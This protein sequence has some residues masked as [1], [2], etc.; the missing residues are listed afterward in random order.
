[1]KLGAMVAVSSFALSQVAVGQAVEWK[2][3]RYTG[4][5]KYYLVVDTSEAV[6]VSGGTALDRLMPGQVGCYTAE[7]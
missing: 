3:G 5:H 7:L 4:T 2:V 6:D 1:M